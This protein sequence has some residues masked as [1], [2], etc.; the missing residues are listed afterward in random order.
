MGHGTNQVLEPQMRVQTTGNGTTASHAF[1]QV[2]GRDGLVQI[3]DFAQ[4]A[5][6]APA[7]GVDRCPFPT[8]ATAVVQNTLTCLL[9]QENAPGISMRIIGRPVI[10]IVG[11]RYMRL[12]RVSMCILT[13]PESNSRDQRSPFRELG[14]GNLSLDVVSYV[15][16]RN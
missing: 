14:S 11:S 5:E 13:A 16:Q 8:I 12:E 3:T 1:R 15:S 6:P 9:A 7:I 4:L 2:L 10:L